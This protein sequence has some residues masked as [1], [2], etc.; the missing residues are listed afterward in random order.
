LTSD[1]F[2]IKIPRVSMSTTARLTRDERKAR[3]RAGLLAA[4]RRVFVERGFHAATLDDI[5][6]E[7]GYTKGAVYSNF[8]GKDDLF[9]AL[10]DEHYERRVGAHRELFEQLELVDPEE[11]RVAV[12]R[13]IYAA[14]EREPAWWALIA[15]FST[16]ASRDAELSARLRA[17][18][19]RFLGALAELIAA[20]GERQGLGYRLSTH[21]VARA[22]GALLRGL[23]LDW[24]LDPGSE[25]RQVVFE[26]AV[27]A[28]L[29]GVA[30][31]LHE[32]SN[33]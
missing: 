21:E 20:V 2:G 23:M 29:R 22:T 30:V 3:T 16:H 17:L 14:Y 5:A 6:E 27:A 10:L 32:R 12:A 11:A 8:R 7:A 1:T 31:P 13:I 15:D 18:R 24:I 19:E 9:L 25:E 26:E 4:A 28:F 33:S